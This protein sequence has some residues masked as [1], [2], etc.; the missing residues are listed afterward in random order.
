MLSIFKD[1]T[2]IIKNVIDIFHKKPESPAPIQII[3]VYSPN[4]RDREIIMAVDKNITNVPAIESDNQ[5]KKPG[6]PKIILPAPESKP[7]QPEFMSDEYLVD[8]AVDLKKTV[9]SGDRLIFTD[10]KFDSESKK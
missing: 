1:V 3:N 8:L 6:S 2:E 9:R 10:P 4:P 5:D 7:D